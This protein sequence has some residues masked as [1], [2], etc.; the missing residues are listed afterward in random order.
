M[1]AEHTTPWLFQRLFWSGN[2]ITCLEVCF[3][4][5]NKWILS[6]TLSQVRYY[7]LGLS[8]KWKPPRILGTYSL[9][10]R[11]ICKQVVLENWR[12]MLIP[13]DEGLSLNI[14]H[15][16][17]YMHIMIIS[18]TP[19][20]PPFGAAVFF[21]MEK[22]SSSYY[23]PISDDR[24]CSAIRVTGQDSPVTARRRELSL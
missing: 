5:F 13:S 20:P 17:C 19:G 14:Y 22:K 2:Y 8:K 18:S 7:R 6:V 11:Q 15:S 10:V 24:N 1:V 9:G 3:H 4:S 21:F 16:S 23:H 12:P